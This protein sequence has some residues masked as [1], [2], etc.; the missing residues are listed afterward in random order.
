MSLEWTRM[1]S[2]LSGMYSCC[3]AFCVAT[4]V[5]M[6][7]LLFVTIVLRLICPT[8]TICSVDCELFREWEGKN[9]WTK[10][11]SRFVT[12]WIGH[13][14]TIQPC[15]NSGYCQTCEEN[16]LRENQLRVGQRWIYSTWCMGA[17]AFESHKIDNWNQQKLH[18]LWY[19]HSMHLWARHPK[20]RFI[21]RLSYHVW[22]VKHQKP[23]IGWVQTEPTITTLMV[24]PT[25][26]L[27]PY[28]ENFAAYKMNFLFK[29]VSIRTYQMRPNHKITRTKRVNVSEYGR[30]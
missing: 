28:E 25:A 16:H 17:P 14:L 21:N 13:L 1:V 4:A 20:H 8:H 19:R 15:T 10:H 11:S 23:Y 2:A 12:S 22:A 6:G 5:C 29:V 7:P 26:L 9:L 30:G 27:R 18:P 24:D 3:S